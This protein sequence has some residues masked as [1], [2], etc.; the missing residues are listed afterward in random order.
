[1]TYLDILLASRFQ[2][3]HSAVNHILQKGWVTRVHFANNSKS[4]PVFS[5]YR[6]EDPALRNHHSVVSDYAKDL[7]IEAAMSDFII[8]DKYLRT[9]FATKTPGQIRAWVVDHMT[10][11]AEFASDPISANYDPDVKALFSLVFQHAVLGSSCL[12]CA[13]SPNGLT[14]YE[15]KGSQGCLQICPV[16]SSSTH[17]KT[18]IV[19]LICKKKHRFTRAVKEAITQRMHSLGVNLVWHYYAIHD[20]TAT[21]RI[22]AGNDLWYY[23]PQIGTFSYDNPASFHEHYPFVQPDDIG[24]CIRYGGL[25]R[26]AHQVLARPDHPMHIWENDRIIAPLRNHNL[27][28]TGRQLPSYNMLLEATLALSDLVYKRKFQF[29]T[30]RL[31]FPEIKHKKLQL[32]LLP[33]LGSKDIVIKTQYSDITPDTLINTV[34]QA[35]PGYNAH[36]V[37]W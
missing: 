32:Q 31:V 9:L 27:P 17:Q 7:Q 15:F 19:G 28:N 5:I 25:T 6:P 36:V 12:R 21:D 1:M 14:R 18:L 2:Y 4:P 30:N 29:S 3:S 13:I 10:A 33:S 24:T 20:E 22:N 37:Y 34:T 23:V 8:H 35:M 26:H 16:V 11:L